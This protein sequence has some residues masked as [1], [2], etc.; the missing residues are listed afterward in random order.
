[1]TSR[2]SSLSDSFGWAL[3]N[4][5]GVCWVPELCRSDD[6]NPWTVRLSA[7]LL[8]P[9]F[10]RTGRVDGEEDDG[11][12][13]VGGLEEGEGSGPR[14]E[15]FG[16]LGAQLQQSSAFTYVKAVESFWL[17]PFDAGNAPIL[18][19]IGYLMGCALTNRCH[20][21]V[22]LPTFV[23]ESLLT[24]RKNPVRDA[25]FADVAEISPDL[26][27]GLNDLRSMSQST[28]AEYMEL[29]G[30][31]TSMSKEEVSHFGGLTS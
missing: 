18:R 23:F 10:K 28:F 31:D 4:E 29:E 2:D 14:K 3:E 26:Q 9:Y 19:W 24:L 8:F 15:F 25:T 27:K 12:R 16:L 30:L 21:G 11:G 17:A 6:P 13:I 7:Q 22:R 20:L 5:S 1:M